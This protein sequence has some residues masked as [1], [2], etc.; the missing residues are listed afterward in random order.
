MRTNLFLAVAAFSLLAAC[1]SREPLQPPPGAPMPVVPEAAPAPPTSEQLLTPPA[2][3][4]P[5]RQDD[6]LRR[7]EKR[8][9]DRFDLPPTG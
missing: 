3:A 2:I 9:D 6:S 7:S 1:G 4:K 8:E 5:E